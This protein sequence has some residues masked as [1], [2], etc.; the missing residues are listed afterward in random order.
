MAE[1]DK[2]II[3]TKDLKIDYKL[4]LVDY[5]ELELDPDGNS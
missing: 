4:N 1:I 3:V 2:Y 5:I